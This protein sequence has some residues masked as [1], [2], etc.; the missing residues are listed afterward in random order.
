MLDEYLWGNVRRISPEAPVPIVERRQPDRSQAA[1]VAATP[2]RWTWRPRWPAWRRTAACLRSTMGTGASG[3][4]RRTLPRVFIEHDIA[5]DEK[6]TL[7]HSAQ[8]RLESIDVHGASTRRKKDLREDAKSQ[9][10]QRRQPIL[11]PSSLASSFATLRLCGRFFF[12]APSQVVSIGAR[13]GSPF[14]QAWSS[15]VVMRSKTVSQSPRLDW[16]NSRMVD[17]GGVFA[18]AQPAPVGEKGMATQ[19]STPNAPARWATEYRWPPPGRGFSAEPPCRRS[20]PRVSRPGRA[21]Q[22]LDRA[23]AELVPA[24]LSFLDAQEIDFGQLGRGAKRVSA[25]ERCGRPVGGAALPDDADTQARD[26]F[27]FVLPVCNPFGAGMQVGYECGDG[28]QGGAH[29]AGDA[30]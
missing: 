8:Q 18:F 24:D 6:A 20:R 1:N 21:R 25:T 17:T 26:R 10:K 2:P 15:A 9:R 19:T 13:P 23:G 14:L 3:E 22:T 12:L 16:R 5:N 28:V 29:Q 7:T 4:I 27:Q 30:Q 11:L